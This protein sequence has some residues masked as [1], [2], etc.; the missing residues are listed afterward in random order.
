[1]NVM[2]IAGLGDKAEILRK[3]A[4][5]QT[6]STGLP[7]GIF[8]KETGKVHMEVFQDAHLPGGKIFVDSSFDSDLHPFLELVLKPDVVKEMVVYQRQFFKN[9][10]I[11]KGEMENSASLRKR[12]RRQSPQM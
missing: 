2:A 6:N 7:E 10:E 5:K 12:K 9:S 8:D 11:W 4:N 3:K 1:V